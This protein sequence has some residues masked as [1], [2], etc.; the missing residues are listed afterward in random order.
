MT[1]IRVTPL[2]AAMCAL[3]TQPAL[4]L[5]VRVTIEN[6]SPAG[7]VALTPVWVGFHDGSFDSYNGGLTSQPGLEVLA[8]DGAT[9]QISADFLAGNTYVQGGVSGVFATAQ[10]SGR[11]DGTLASTEITAAP[12]LTPGESSTQ[13]FTIATDAS[14]QYFSYASM[15]LPTND[16]FVANGNP[17]AHDLSS[18]LG[19]SGSIS[20]LIGTP[21]GGVNDAGTEAEDYNTSAANGLFGLPGGQGAGDTPAGSLGLAITNVVGPDPIGALNFPGGAPAAFDF[22]DPSLY[23]AGGIGRITITAIPEPSTVMLALLGGVGLATRRRR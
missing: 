13:V 21:D 14:N 4:G 11:V 8:E 15:V 20:F 22:N 16:F 18:I 7:G 10:T 17:L 23:A 9:G 5:D 1:W 2:L 6:V 19:G 12:P 3:A